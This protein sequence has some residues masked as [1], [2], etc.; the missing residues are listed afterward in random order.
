M[1]LSKL[2]MML[3]AISKLNIK[4]IFKICFFNYFVVEVSGSFIQE[5]LTSNRMFN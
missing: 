1:Y 3:M 2:K 5:S 4:H